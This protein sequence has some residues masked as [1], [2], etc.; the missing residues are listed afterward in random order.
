MLER[1][2]V[3]GA[4]GQG[5][6]LI[7]K[8]TARLASGLFPHVA[9][10]P[11]YGAEVRGGTSNCHLTISGALIAGPI[12]ERFDSMLLMSQPGVDAFLDRLDSGGV[13]WINSSMCRAREAPS[14][15]LIPAT[16]MANR[17]G[18]AKA[19]NFVML[20]AWL[21]HK[22]LIPL[23]TVSREIVRQF[24]DAQGKLNVK[25]LEA[26]CAWRP[27]QHGISNIQGIR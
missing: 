8:L 25:A 9:L 23:E 27:D 20:G 18:S 11:G 15:R 7:G 13:A 4:G 12:P 24:P 16:E 22:K 19:A 5:V 1:V 6:L 17:I 26:G 3:A 2:L 14:R 10:V 21:A